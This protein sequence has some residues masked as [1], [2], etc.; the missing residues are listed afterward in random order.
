MNPFFALAACS[1]LGP[2][3]PMRPPQG[4][5]H[6][7][8]SRAPYGPPDLVVD[9]EGA[10]DHA[11]ISAAIAAAEDRSSI[12]VRPCT[13]HER[14]DFLG[15]TLWIT[16]SDGAETTIIDADDAGPAVTAK[17]G[18]GDSTALVGFTLDDSEGE[19]VDVELAALRLQ[20][21]LITD[22]D[23]TYAVRS[24]SADLELVDVTIDASNDLWSFSV[25]SDRGTVAIRGGFIQCDSGDGVFLGHG[26]FLV[27]GTEISC[28]GRAIEIEHSVGRIQRS[29][30]T[31]DIHALT[32]EDHLDDLIHLEN[33]AV[34]GDIESEFGTITVRNSVVSGQLR[35]TTTADTVIVENSIFV[36]ASCAISADSPLGPVRNNDFAGGPSMCAGADIVGTDGN[37]S[38][39]PLFVSPPDFH[40]QAG[41]PLID[42]GVANS[43]YNDIDGSRNDIGLHGGHFN[44]DGGW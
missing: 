8:L 32:E 12:E 1:W 33:D 11:T 7:G 3:E 29:R 41:S 10:G 9:C 44:I 21:V 4:R 19:A 6:A 25:L 27:D 17:R 42:A 36:G 43:S 5:S 34:A 22:T 18:E 30:L 38:T 23:G 20:D 16:S 26:G 14:I 24:Q 37:L 35:L 15:K 31:G 28:S 39:D 40:L 2:A 13:Y